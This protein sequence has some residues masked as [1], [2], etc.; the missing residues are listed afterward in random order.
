LVYS[1]TCKYTP[2][3]QKLYELIKS[4]NEEGLSYRRI[5]KYLNERGIPTHTGKKWGETGN[6]VYS[7]LKKYRERIK[8]LELLNREYEPVWGQMEIK[9]EKV[10]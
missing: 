9:W 5:T 6:S 10:V 3:Q 4:L 1:Q 8:R 2:E 7:V